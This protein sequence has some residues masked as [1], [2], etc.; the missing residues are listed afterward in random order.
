MRIGAVLCASCFDT[1]AIPAKVPDVKVVITKESE[2][3]V[4]KLSEICALGEER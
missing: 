4:E 2:E 1:A 3:S